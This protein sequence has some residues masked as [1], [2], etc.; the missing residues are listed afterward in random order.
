MSIPKNLLYDDSDHKREYCI[1]ITCEGPPSIKIAA[2]F[3]EK[4]GIS[5][6]HFKH[7]VEAGHVQL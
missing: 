7:L 4:T 3:C 5:R 6:S 2:V 1:E